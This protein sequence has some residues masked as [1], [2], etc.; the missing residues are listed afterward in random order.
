MRFLLDK[1]GVDV[2]RA[3]H[4]GRRA[5]HRAAKNGHRDIV[6][7]LLD[8][9]ANV[10]ATDAPEKTAL[11]F[12]SERGHWDIVKL[13]LDNNAEVD[14]VE[15]CNKDTALHIAA[16]KGHL[17]VVKTLLESG[18]K[19]DKNNEKGETAHEIA[20][21]ILDVIASSSP[22][23][24]VIDYQEFL[25]NRESVARTLKRWP[26]QVEQ[27]REKKEAQK[28]RIKAFLCASRRK[29][30]MSP[31]VKRVV[32]SYLIEDIKPPKTTDLLPED[33]AVRMQSLVRGHLARK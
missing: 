26:L 27:A 25:K 18:A 9:R 20:S 21:E 22:N 10:D 19:F 12:A 17:K 29:N 31:D 23:N 6:K 11:H 5:L 4:S 7:M 30:S 33:Y 28:E 8:S 2:N 13:L 3:E 32:V 1:D 16:E 15:F 14:K 24:Y